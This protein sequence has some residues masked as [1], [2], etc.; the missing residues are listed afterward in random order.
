MHA[1]STHIHA[2][3]AAHH[4]HEKDD[5]PNAKEERELVFELQCGGVLALEEEGERRKK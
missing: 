4:I 3:T 1:H 5:G 2:S